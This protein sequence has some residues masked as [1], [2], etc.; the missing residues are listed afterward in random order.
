MTAIPASRT[1]PPTPAQASA[2]RWP[3]RQAGEPRPATMPGGK[4]EVSPST[5]SS[6]CAGTSRRWRG[7]GQKRVS[8]DHGGRDVNELAVSLERVIAHH[9]ER[10]RIVDGVALHENALGA[11]NHGPATKRSF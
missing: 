10:A 1:N 2:R 5:S 6:A 9:P 7:P 4:S 8:V 11:F 3:S